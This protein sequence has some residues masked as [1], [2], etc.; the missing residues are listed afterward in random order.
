[1][2]QVIRLY[3]DINHVIKG[4]S[5]MGLNKNKQILHIWY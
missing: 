2:K 4:C 3:V 1:M 5:F